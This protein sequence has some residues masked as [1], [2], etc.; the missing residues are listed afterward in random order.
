MADFSIERSWLEG[1]L[2]CVAGVDEVGRG[3]LC[4][5]VVAAAVVFPRSLILGE[6]PDWVRRTN[7]SKLLSPRLRA[8][9]VRRIAAE[10]RV[11]IGWSVSGEVDRLNVFRASQAAMRRAVAALAPPPDLVLVDGVFLRDFPLPQ[12]SLPGGD[13]ISTSIAAASIAAKVLRDE[14]LVFCAGLYEG[15]GLER[16][17]GYGTR[18]HYQALEALGPTPFHRRSF[19]LQSERTLFE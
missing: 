10:T 16:H 13:R 7:D 8:E 11:G 19:T 5:P 18:G 14:L 4:G 6:P 3:A 2:R 17:K 1:G 9:L 15:Y 12:R